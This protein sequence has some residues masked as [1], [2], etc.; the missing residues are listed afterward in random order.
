MPQLARFAEAGGGGDLMR[1]AVTLVEP[2]VAVIL[3]L[4]RL[5]Q[6]GPVWY[7]LQNGL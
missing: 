5:E 6:P 7:G 4:D 1:D 2:F 3:A